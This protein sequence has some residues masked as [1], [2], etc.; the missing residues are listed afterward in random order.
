MIP[1]HKYATSHKFR[2]NIRDWTTTHS[3]T[4]SSEGVSDRPLIV[5]LNGHDAESLV[6]AGKMIAATGVDA[7][8][9]NLGEYV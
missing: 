3:N 8:D 7:I 1:A 9:L 5:Q 4:C 2:E 6:A